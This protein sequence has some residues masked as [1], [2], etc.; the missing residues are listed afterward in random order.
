MTRDLC[1][2][3]LDVRLGRLFLMMLAVVVIVMY[4]RSLWNGQR[5][6]HNL[7]GEDVL[8]RVYLLI[9]DWRCAACD[10][11]VCKDAGS[12][13]DWNAFDQKSTK[14]NKRELK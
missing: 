8:N 9:G 3:V 2:K 6:S 5:S 7:F 1:A 4:W 10:G 11:I 14:R 12:K 13:V